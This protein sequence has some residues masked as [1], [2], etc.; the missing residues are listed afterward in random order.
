ML[1]SKLSPG[2]AIWFGEGVHEYAD[3]VPPLVQS[4]QQYVQH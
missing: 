1:C 4:Q 2:V 3:P